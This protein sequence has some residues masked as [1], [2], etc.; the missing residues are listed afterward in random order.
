MK[1]VIIPLKEK[2]SEKITKYKTPSQ[3][4]KICLDK[5]TATMETKLPTNDRK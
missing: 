3:Q 2:P 1:N 5:G 4:M